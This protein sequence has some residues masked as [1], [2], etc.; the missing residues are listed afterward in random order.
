MAN[1]TL[2]ELSRALG[3]LKKAAKEDASLRPLARDLRERLEAVEA[4]TQDI[5]AHSQEA[6]P[7]IKTIQLLSRTV[8]TETTALAE[9]LVPYMN[10]PRTPRLTHVPAA[11]VQLPAAPVRTQEVQQE[12]EGVLEV[13]EETVKEVAK[14][15]KPLPYDFL[16]EESA[17]EIPP[18]PVRV[19]EHATLVDTPKAE[20]VSFAEATEEVEFAEA[21]EEVEFAE[22]PQETA[23]L[24]SVDTQE[25]M[26]SADS[27]AT[28][29]GGHVFDDDELLELSGHV[30]LDGE[31]DSGIIFGALS[32]EEEAALRGDERMEGELETPEMAAE[33]EMRLKPMEP[34]PATNGVHPP[35][36]DDEEEEFALAPLKPLTIDEQLPRAGRGLSRNLDE[37]IVRKPRILIVG[38][39]PMD[40]T[41]SD[42]EQLFGS[43]YEWPNDPV[44]QMGPL[45]RYLR[46]QPTFHTHR[47]SVST[48]AELKEL[49]VQ[50]GKVADLDN[51]S[52]L[53]NDHRGF[54]RIDDDGGHHAIVPAAIVLTNFD[55]IVNNFTHDEK[56]QPTT[57][58]AKVTKKP[59]STELVL[60]E[61]PKKPT[62]AMSLVERNDYMAR[63]Q[64]YQE[65]QA[66]IARRKKEQQQVS[67]QE[68]QASRLKPEV[69]KNT[70]EERIEQIVDELV[71]IARDR[72]HLFKSIGQSVT[73][74]PEFLLG[75][76]MNDM[77]QL[78]SVAICSTLLTDRREQ[79]RSK[80]VEE[81]RA[82]VEAEGK[83]Y[84]ETIPE[85]DRDSKEFKEWLKKQP[86]LMEKEVQKRSPMAMAKAEDSDPVFRKLKENNIVVI[87][88]LN[89][90]K[91]FS[92]PLKKDGSYVNRVINN[93]YSQDFEE[94]AANPDSKHN[95]PDFA[96]PY[97]LIMRVIKP[98]VSLNES[99][100][101]DTQAKAG[102]SR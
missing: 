12:A 39:P 93:P 60:L 77:A 8:T 34:K 43:N 102:A 47:T 76:Y 66:E 70:R 72:K 14:Q 51:E 68:E 16:N 3:S 25:A 90:K 75:L 79:L 94:R 71:E 69:T 33:R 95:N 36:M 26:A 18:L 83:A 82:V 96:G 28:I 22:A 7:N 78:P 35:I 91:T 61:E 41:V 56:P 4:L 55:T 57:A 86:A 99:W 37:N 100:R 31:D 45:E 19:L 67:Q 87:D 11:P 49:R 9:V 23:E 92:M 2:Q 30:L 53:P 97:E 40:L 5:L 50:P 13:T 52:W 58:L 20:E 101:K 15:H 1:P 29:I 27:G 21:P 80:A 59:E 81:L 64:A 98:L 65:Q 24:S 17:D 88:F 54:I 6:K 46:R 63:V 62:G 84:V 10:L 44:L 89:A 42:K 74:R 48:I 38:S 85:D 32:A 73:T